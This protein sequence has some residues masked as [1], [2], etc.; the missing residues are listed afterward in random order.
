MKQLAILVAAIALAIAA[1]MPAQAAYMFGD[2]ESLTTMV[3]VG[4]TGSE[5]EALML[6]HKTTTHN[7]LLPW[8][9]S[10]DGYVLVRKSDTGQYYEMTEAEIAEWQQ[11]GLL[12]NPLPAYEISLFDKVMG[13]LLWPTLAVIGVIYLVGFMRKRG[14]AMVAAE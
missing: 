12:P 14:K 2:D 1:A 4:V 9:M 11:A 8:S 7:F 10:D 6:G 13:H 5:G 3:D